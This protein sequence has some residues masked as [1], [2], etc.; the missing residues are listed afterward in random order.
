MLYLKCRLIANIYRDISDHC[1]RTGP[2][3]HYEQRH[4]AQKLSV[5]SLAAFISY[6]Q[7]ISHSSNLMPLAA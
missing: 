4:E 2:W 3:T 5:I 1:S 7:F 6:L